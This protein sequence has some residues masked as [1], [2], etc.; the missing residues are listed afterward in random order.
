LTFVGAIPQGELCTTI[1]GGYSIKAIMAPQAISPNDPI[2][3]FPPT[4]GDILYFFST[5]NQSLRLLLIF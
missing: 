5:A 3:E 1:P 4:D 2:S